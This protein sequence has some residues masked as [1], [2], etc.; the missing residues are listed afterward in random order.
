[1]ESS[2]ITLG[3]AGGPRVWTPADGAEPR[4]G[5]ATAV[6]VGDRWYLVDCGQSV[7]RQIMKA[8]LNINNLGG[9]FITHLHS[10]HTI[11]LVNVLALSFP[12]FTRPLPQV[13]VYGPGNRRALPPVSPRATENVEPVFADDPTPGM[14]QIVD[15]TLRSHATDINDR[16]LDNLRPNPL[17]IWR[18]VDIELPE[19]CGFD[20]NDNPHPDMAPFV[21]HEDDWVTVTAT[22]VVHPPIAPSFAFR[23]DTRDGKSVV[24]SGD[25][26][27][28]ENLTRLAECS[29]VLL[30]E[31]I[32]VDWIYRFNDVNTEMGRAAIDHHKKSH[33]LPEDAGRV[34]ADASVGTL[35]L[36]HLVP[37]TS[38]N[39]VWE[40]ATSTYSGKLLIPNDMDII[41]L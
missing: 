7:Y 3:T 25:T 13:P 4:C 14:K 18:G 31:A 16:V 38:P 41:P 40:R 32:D 9:I 29:D 17:E 8:G 35:A 23:F 33:T 26:R 24:I 34:A 27:H 30:H 15:Y 20:A 19:D 39:Q 37:G 21:I 11:D 28:S 22:L 36:H 6:V 5:I 12:N 2:I 1:M 10:D